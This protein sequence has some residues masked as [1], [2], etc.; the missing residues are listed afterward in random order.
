MT[1]F[2]WT[3][4]QGNQRTV[5]HC[6]SLSDAV[7]LAMAYDCGRVYRGCECVWSVR[8]DLLASEAAEGSNARIDEIVETAI[9]TAAARLR[10]A[11]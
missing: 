11:A 8:S 4:R 5:A 1:G 3:V 7:R 10:Q 2:P 6:Y 9:A